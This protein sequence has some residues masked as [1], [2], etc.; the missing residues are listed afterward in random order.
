MWALSDEYGWGLCALCHSQ[1]WLS[2]Y[3]VFVLQGH[4]SFPIDVSEK[5]PKSC[6][7]PNTTSEPML[8][9]PAQLDGLDNVKSSKAWHHHFA[10][11]SIQTFEPHHVIHTAAIK[12]CAIF[13]IAGI[14]ESGDRE[15]WSFTQ[16]HTNLSYLVSLPKFRNKHQIREFSMNQF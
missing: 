3:Q 1:L 14:N 9:S 11:F 13:Q 8:L 7:M 12:T 15:V 5:P 6:C 2:I 4:S 16:S 10:N